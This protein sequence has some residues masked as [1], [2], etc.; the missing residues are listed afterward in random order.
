VEP[1]IQGAIGN[2]E[3]YSP[4]PECG[5]THVTLQNCVPPGL[6]ASLETSALAA[7]AHVP[8]SIS[9]PQ[10]Y[11]PGV[12]TLNVSADTIITTP[13][14]KEPFKVGYIAVFSIEVE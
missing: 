11:P 6:V 9:I 12:Y 7:A 10:D 13:D 2:L 14:Q 4:F 8:L 1:R 3:V 5:S